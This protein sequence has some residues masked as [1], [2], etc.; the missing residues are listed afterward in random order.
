MYNL[1]LKANLV[2]LTKHLLQS[3]PRMSN[4]YEIYPIIQLWPKCDLHKKAEIKK[5]VTG[6]P[7]ICHLVARKF[8]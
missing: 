5:E 4:I 2:I 3:N 7:V 6:L 8:T 1:G